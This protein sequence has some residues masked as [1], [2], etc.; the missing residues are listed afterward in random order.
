M[1]MF[2]DYQSSS[3]I[4]DNF[5]RK[6]KDRFLKQLQDQLFFRETLLKLSD[7]SKFQVYRKNWLCNQKRLFFG[8]LFFCL[9]SLFAIYMIS[10]VNHI[11]II[12][13]NNQLLFPI[14]SN[15]RC[16]NRS[17]SSQFRRGPLNHQRLPNCIIVGVRKCGT[18]ALLEFLAIHPQ[19]IKVTDE[20]HFFDDD[21]HYNNGIE[22]YR[23]RMPFT[24]EHNVVIEKTPAYYV[25]ESVPERIYA[26]NSSIK[27]ILIVRDPVTRLISDYAQLASNRLK[28][29]RRIE[30]FEET[31]LY[32][33]GQVNA[34]YKAIRISM[35]A[36]FF[37]RWIKL[38]PKNQIHVVDGD[39]FVYDPLPELEKIESFLGLPHRISEE[40][41]IY[42]I[43]KGFYCIRIDDGT[44]KCLNENKGRRHPEINPFV[45]QK[46]RKF[47]RPYNQY[48][49]RLVG[50]N[51]LWP[52]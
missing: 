46:L 34:S 2:N 30:T 1:I 5:D 4:I 45:I 48:F 10:V 9:I 17:R 49:F 19:I 24:A 16:S 11:Q 52:D 21:K 8:I 44:E 18:R 39:R 37:S 6:S 26:M 27:I 14:N 38:F 42:N 36:V 40:N 15:G 25:T 23:Q 28:K 43:T 41:L 32:P 51:F 29:D 3:K 22:W 31:V 20:M 12:F 33:N 47:Y 13:S 50:R 35:F 7:V